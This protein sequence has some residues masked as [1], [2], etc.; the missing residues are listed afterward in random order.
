MSGESRLQTKQKKNNL[1]KLTINNKRQL[2]QNKEQITSTE[3]KWSEMTEHLRRDD[4][5]PHTVYRINHI[6]PQV[7]YI[8]FLQYINLL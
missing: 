1:N 8:K 7:K 6:V 2:Q 5:N 3:I 4:A